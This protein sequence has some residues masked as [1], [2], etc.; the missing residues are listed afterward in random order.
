MSV[1]NLAFPLRYPMLRCRAMASPNY[2]SPMHYPTKQRR[3]LT[4]RSL[5]APRRCLKE[6]HSAIQCRC[7]A[8]CYHTS[9]CLRSV[10]LDCT[11]QCLCYTR[12]HLSLHVPT[13]PSLLRANLNDAAAMQ[14]NADADLYVLDIQQFVSKPAK[15]GI[16][17]LADTV[18]AAILQPFKDDTLVD[19]RAKYPKLRFCACRD[20]FG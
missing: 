3:C 14:C 20:H 13:M 15:T 4:N 10:L 5:A 8:V 18:E 2:A 6:L 19:I 9:L 11:I 17:P 12:P 1:L 16:A 7:S